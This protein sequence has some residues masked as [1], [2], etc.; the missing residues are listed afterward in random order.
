MQES[1]HTVKAAMFSGMSRSERSESQ[2][3]P[4]IMQ[5]GTLIILPG[6]SCSP[7]P[8]LV[9]QRLV[10]PCVYV[11][12]YIYIICVYIYIY[13]HVYIHTCTYI[14]NS[15]NTITTKGY[16]SHVQYQFIIYIQTYKG[17][18]MYKVLLVIPVYVYVYAYI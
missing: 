14:H 2:V 7:A 8:D 4:G 9:L 12:V 16:T 13:T 17:I 6:R 3:V 11:C 15:M 5:F 18:D 1:R 10:V